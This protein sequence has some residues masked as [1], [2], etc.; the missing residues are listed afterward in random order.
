LTEE[1]DQNV[2]ESTDESGVIKALRIQLK[3]AQKDL[4][5]RPARED[6]ESEI[7][8]Q[9]K[10]ESDAA[11]LLTEQGHPSGLARFM[12]SEIGDAEITAEAVSGFLQGLG[13]PEPVSSEGQEQ[14]PN[15]QLAEVTSLA[16]AVTAAAS[17]ASA[18]S[19]NQRIAKAQ[20]PAELEAIMEEIGAVQS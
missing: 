5:S 12:L 3:E 10:R 19:V 9:L 1:I 2:D 16:S 20:S 14:S 11:A 17:G 7:R 6:L 15:Q 13:F 4:K 18:D 8:A